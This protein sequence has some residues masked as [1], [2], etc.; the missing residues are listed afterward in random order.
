VVKLKTEIILVRHS[1]PLKLQMFLKNGNLQDLNELIPLSL[2]GELKAKEMS[3]KEIFND[4]SV[5]ISSKYIR[6]LDTAKYIVERN[7]CKFVVDSDL[8]ERKLGTENRD[9]KFWVTQLIEP[10][11]KVKDGESQKEV[12][13]RMLSVVKES[14]NKYRGGKIVLVS[15]ATAIT[16]LL[17]NWCN[18]EEV[19]LENKRRKLTFN[20]NVVINDNFMTPDIFKLVFDHDVIKSIERII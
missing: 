5:V 11:A 12:R 1:E 18:L 9:K 15:H 3:Q 20:N 7:D 2:N 14:L 6:A 17:M 10:D 8:G 13:N 4:V 16:F 19:E